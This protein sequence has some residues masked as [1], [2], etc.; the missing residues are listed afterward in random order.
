MAALAAAYVG[1]FHDPAPRHVP[2]GVLDAR[3]AAAG[4]ASR[5]AFDAQREPTLAALVHDLKA[6]KIAAGLAG[7]TLYVA[8]GES[9]TT[10]ATVTAVFGKQISGLKVADIAPL[11]PGDP[12]GNRLFYLVIA[13]AFGG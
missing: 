13:S 4:D 11:E 6:R 7:R 8:S 9:Y 1:A 2:I 3:T 12:R 5:G 10:T